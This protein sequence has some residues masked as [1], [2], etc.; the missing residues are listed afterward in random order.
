[1]HIINACTSAAV[2]SACALVGVL[3]GPRVPERV[4]L[5]RAMAVTA[6]AATAACAWALWH[7]ELA[8]TTLTFVAV[9]YVAGELRARRVRGEGESA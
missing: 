9:T 2:G 8:A 3:T 1:V 4:N 7:H 5:D 6:T